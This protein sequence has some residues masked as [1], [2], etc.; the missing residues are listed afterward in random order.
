MAAPSGCDDRVAFYDNFCSNLDDLESE[1]PDFSEDGSSSVCQE[2]GNHI[3]ASAVVCCNVLCGGES[4]DP[5]V[6]HSNCVGFDFDNSD[7]ILLNHDRDDWFCPK[8]RSS[9]GM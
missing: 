7:A 9:E 5:A 8:C 1:V 6:F 2:C 3:F 4:G